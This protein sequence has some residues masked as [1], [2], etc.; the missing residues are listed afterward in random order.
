MVTC[1]LF[2]ILRLTKS[3][4]VNNVTTPTPSQIKISCFFIKISRTKSDMSGR[5]ISRS[6]KS[7]GCNK[8]SEI[9]SRAISRV[10]N[11]KG[12][13]RRA[14][15]GAEQF[16]PSPPSLSPKNLS[17]KILQFNKIDNQKNY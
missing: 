15:L 14:R 4:R 3:R 5:A 1:Y 11:L 6:G 16:S 7:K 12:A 17:S 13:T 2:F 8:A 10:E 9:G